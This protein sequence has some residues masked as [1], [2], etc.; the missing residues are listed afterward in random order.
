MRYQQAI[1]T[2][3]PDYSVAAMV[4]L[5]ALEAGQGD[6]TQ[7]R[8]RYQQAINTGHPEYAPWAMVNLGELEAEQGDL[9][10]ARHWYQQ[11]I[12]TGHLQI[13][14]RAQQ[15]L[16]ALDQHKRDRERGEHFGRYGYL[17]YAD[18]ALMSQASRPHATPGPDVAPEGQEPTQAADPRLWAGPCSPAVS[19]QSV[20]V[21]RIPCDGSNQRS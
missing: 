18:P 4:N 15:D 16:H 3:H 7:A 21:R 8:R 1:N 14:G 13:A 12:S 9:A 2:G 17:V 11:A 19:F 10:Q 20:Q 6:P 5:G